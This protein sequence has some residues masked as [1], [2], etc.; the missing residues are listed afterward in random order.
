MAAT[1]NCIVAKLGGEAFWS[2]KT[3][4]IKISNAILVADF[5]GVCKKL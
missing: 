4:V 5:I 3:L 1:S 2:S